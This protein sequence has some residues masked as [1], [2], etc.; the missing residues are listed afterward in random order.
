MGPGAA[1]RLLGVVAG[2]A[3]LA[4]Y[5]LPWLHGSG[6]LAG[7]TFSGFDLVRLGDVLPLL[8]EVPGG[9]PVV[10]ALRVA[11]V[12]VVVA[13]AWLT[14]L[15][16]AHRWHV[17]YAISGWYLVATLLLLLWVHIDREGTSLPP[18]GALTWIAGV[19]CFLTAEVLGSVPRRRARASSP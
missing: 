9:E 14:L 19:A 7:Q 16:P 13:A 18:A 5:F 2:P 3:V 17:A 12:G 1:A 10:R 8:V 6:V 11:S 4:G 15:A